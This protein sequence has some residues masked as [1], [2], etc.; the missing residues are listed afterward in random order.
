MLDLHAKISQ[1]LDRLALPLQV[2]RC[3]YC[4]LINGSVVSTT[5]KISIH[6]IIIKL[7]DLYIT[8]TCKAF[9]I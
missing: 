1:F 4:F 2:G 3:K 5:T 9:I 7:G 6:T 8:N